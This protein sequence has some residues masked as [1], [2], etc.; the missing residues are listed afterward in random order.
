MTVTS[1]EEVVDAEEASEEEEEESSEEEEDV[2]CD[3][4]AVEPWVDDDEGEWN[5]KSK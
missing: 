1:N 4:V 2:E 3:L 5:D